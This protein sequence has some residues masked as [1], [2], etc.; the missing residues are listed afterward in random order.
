MTYKRN[1]LLYAAMIIIV[2]ILGLYSRKMADVMPNFLN[3]YLGDALWA[4]MIFIAFGFIFI[5]MDTK[6]VALI[7]LSF[8]Y[9]IELSQLYHANWIDTIRK[10]TLGGLILG[11][12]FLWSD[13]LAYAIGIAAGVIIE[14][15]S[16]MIR[17]HYMRRRL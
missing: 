6:I 3:T 2:I 12:G 16:E 4:L 17:N 10:T 1:R 14:F 15:L 8:C 5:S 11:Y 9:L 13:L 7:G